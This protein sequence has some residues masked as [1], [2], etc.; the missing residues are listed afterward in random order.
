MEESINAYGWAPFEHPSLSVKRAIQRLDPQTGR[1]YF[2]DGSF[3]DNVDHI[4]YESGYT[5][6][7]PFSSKVQGLIKMCCRRLPVVYQ[8]TWDIEDPTL[9]FVGMA[10]PHSSPTFCNPTDYC[11]LKALHSA[12]T[13][14]KLQLSLDSLQA[15]PSRYPLC[16]T[17]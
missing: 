17:S 4:I 9:T 15:V 8:H 1:I 6:G 3:L 2:T 10:N 14:G 5:F 13:N 7:F 11:R 12:H 16:R